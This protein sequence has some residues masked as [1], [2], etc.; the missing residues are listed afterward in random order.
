MAEDSA[1]TGVSPDAA[2][3]P[4]HPELKNSNGQLEGQ[5]FC[6]GSIPE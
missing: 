3:S 2:L 5:E 1:F 6:D 4:S